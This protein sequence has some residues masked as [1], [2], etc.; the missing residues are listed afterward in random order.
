LLYTTSKSLRC[1]VLAWPG[2]VKGIL[3]NELF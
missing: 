1:I 2:K 3:F